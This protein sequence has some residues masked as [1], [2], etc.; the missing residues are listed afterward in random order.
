MVDEREFLSERSGGAVPSMRIAQPED[1]GCRTVRFAV[2]R[3]VVSFGMMA[4][5]AIEPLVEQQFREYPC[6][7]CSEMV[8][9]ERIAIVQKVMTA[10][11]DI[12]GDEFVS[13]VMRSAE[14]QVLRSLA[15]KGFVRVE[16]GPEDR[17]QITFPVTATVGVV[18]PKVVATIQERAAVHQERL[19]REVMAEA[20]ARIDNWDSY[21]G[22][23]GILKQDASRLIQE[24]LRTVLERRRER[25]G[26][27]ELAAP[28]D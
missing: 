10:A 14:R 22:R 13:H 1:A 24:A 26:T 17:Q 11:A 3:R 23:S 4:N 6:P 12:G 19:A 7:E 15:G 28:L 20:D 16:R 9:M 27:G 18:S 25:A 8:A 21:Y 2:Y 5:G